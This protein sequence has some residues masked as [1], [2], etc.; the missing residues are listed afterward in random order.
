MKIEVNRKGYT[1]IR[2]RVDSPTV[3]LVGYGDLHVGH[4]TYREDRAI[5]VRDYIKDNPCVVILMGDMMENATKTSV[6]AGV[7]DQTMNPAQQMKYLTAFLE[8]IKSKCIGYVKG[9]HEERSYKNSG[10][11]P[12]MTLCERLDIPYC[13]WEFF[14]QIATEKRAYT[15]YAVHSYMGSKSLGLA[16]HRTEE[17]EKMVGGTEIIMRGHA[18]KKGYQESEFLEI[19][20]CNNCVQL[21]QRF[22]V[23]TGHYM[24]RDKSYA[25]SKPMRG[26]PMGTIA[27]ELNMNRAAEKRIRP[28]DL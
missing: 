27:L 19:D 8:P 22:L 7:Y 18:H 5:Q 28:I 11:D 9:N 26:Y 25:A 16:L 2:C 12:A 1:C 24:E 6:G 3:T 13:H 23:S 10:I 14:G 21:K 4:F 15:V 17:I 20:K